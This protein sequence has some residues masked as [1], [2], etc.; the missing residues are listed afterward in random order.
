MS[1]FSDAVP[2]GT[3]TNVLCTWLR[4]TV[5]DASVVNPSCSANSW[6]ANTTFMVWTS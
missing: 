5:P 2:S 6:A 3:R 1:I 4:P